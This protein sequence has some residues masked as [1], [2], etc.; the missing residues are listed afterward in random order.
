MLRTEISRHTYG[1][2]SGLYRQVDGLESQAR[3][4]VSVVLAERG[5]EGQP[6]S[7]RLD[8]DED[9]N[10]YLICRSEKP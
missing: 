7:I 8:T 4:L 3:L 9:G 6:D 5:I 2:L 10:H 1:V